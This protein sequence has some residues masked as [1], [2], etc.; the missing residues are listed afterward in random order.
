MNVTYDNTHLSTH[1]QEKGEGDEVPEVDGVRS[2]GHEG[3]KVL[4]PPRCLLPTQ[5]VVEHRDGDEGGSAEE[6]RPNRP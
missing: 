6:R 4:D 3:G 2:G 5:E 1:C